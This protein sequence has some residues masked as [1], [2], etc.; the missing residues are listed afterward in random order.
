[1]DTAT[2][3]L[4]PASKDDFSLHL[5]EQ[6]CFALYSASLAMN[7]AY[8]D[9]LKPLG[10]TY[11][12]YLVFLVLWESDERSVSDIGQRLYLDSATLT[13]LLK[14]M[15]AAGWVRRDR[16][17]SDERVVVVSLTE[18]G[19]AMRLAAHSVPAGLLCRAA[20]PL[21]QLATLRSELNGLRDRLM[22]NG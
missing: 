3:C 22:Q 7:K 21:E 4:T 13:P 15:E 18:A 12:Q 5:D 11:S 2:T 16:K 17:A 1:M 9:A 20:L 14:R 10:I 6:L 8:R 19:R